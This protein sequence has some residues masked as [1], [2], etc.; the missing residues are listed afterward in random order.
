MIDT[1]DQLHVCSSPP[2]GWTIVKLDITL[3]FKLETRFESWY[4]RLIFQ[5][6]LFTFI[7]SISHDQCHIL[8]QVYESGIQSEREP[9][10][11]E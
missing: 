8:R 11:E 5:P 7:R 6:S 10:G 2:E 3:A 9:E 1:H 4:V